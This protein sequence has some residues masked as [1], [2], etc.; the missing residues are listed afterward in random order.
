MKKIVITFGVISGVISSVLMVGMLGFVDRIGFDNGQIVGYSLMV[1]SFL[2]V[3][4]GVRSYREN[5]GHGYI[6]FGRGLAVGLLI[7]LI[8]TAFYVATWEVVYFKITPEFGDKFTAYVVEQTRKS[9]AT[10]PVI[11]AKIKEMQ[12]FKAMYDKPLFNMAFTFIEP[13]P[14]GLPM[15]LLSALILRKRRKE[16]EAEANESETAGLA[17]SSQS[18]M[19]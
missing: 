1:L 18:V 17:S 7:M 9:G 14:V 12:E 4:F 13:M 5:V 11:D 3:F 2:M 8:S 10:Q 15:V 16:E 6:T 19:S